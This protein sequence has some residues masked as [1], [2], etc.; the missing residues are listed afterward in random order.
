M[1]KRRETVQQIV[2]MLYPQNPETETRW[3]GIEIPTD[4][5]TGKFAFPNN[6]ELN[7]KRIRS[8]IFPRNSGDNMVAPSGND[9]VPD[10][11]I[12]ATYLEIR[13]N[14]DNVIYQAPA[15]FF[16]E[17]DGDRRQRYVD[18]KGFNPQTSFV[19]VYDTSTYA[20]TDSIFILIEYSD[21]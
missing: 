19:T 13:R 20:L 8:I 16:Q 21:K 3:I 11:C 18:I 2:P 7:G 15:R 1:D 17:T 10:V 6:N 5:S 9:V 12:G 14:S 4:N